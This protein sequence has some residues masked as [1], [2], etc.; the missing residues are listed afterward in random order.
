MMLHLQLLV[1]KKRNE[2]VCVAS[3]DQSLQIHCRFLVYSLQGER[4]NIQNCR[5]PKTWRNSDLKSMVSG[6]KSSILPVS[7]L[8]SEISWIK[9]AKFAISCRF[10]FMAMKCQIFFVV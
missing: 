3:E 4:L 7:I 2:K 5:I 8:E 9:L 6:S 10:D 1:S